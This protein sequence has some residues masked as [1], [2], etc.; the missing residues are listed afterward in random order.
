MSEDKKF[1]ETA[2]YNTDQTRECEKT[3]NSDGKRKQ[4]N[5]RLTKSS[6]EADTENK[7]DNR[8]ET[9]RQETPILNQRMSIEVEVIPDSN[10]SQN[11]GDVINNESQISNLSKNKSQKKKAISPESQTHETTNTKDKPKKIFKVVY[12]KNDTSIAPETKHSRL[13][14]DNQRLKVAR[15]GVNSM[16]ILLKHR[17]EK[18]GLVLKKV[19]VKKLFGNIN[20]Q[21]WFVKR[22]MKYIFA[23]KHANKKVIKIMIK[24]DSIFKKL[25]NLTF[26]DF[27]IN[28][29]LV[30]NRYLP[31]NKRTV[32]F[33][34]HLENFIKCLEN[35]FEKNE[36]EFTI[37]ENEEYVDKLMITGT[38]LIY[39]INGGGNY[40]PRCNR[41]RI[42]NKICFIKYK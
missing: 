41:K 4:D 9:E 13:T 6:T 18:Q 36:N 42:K 34:A 40:D 14:K 17:C 15:M 30:N 27:Y 5:K 32:L 10:V 28:Y 2:E 33:L 26:E 25:V 37:E 23:S 35:E 1:Y 16:F 12:R 29:F 7:T 24:K 3:E 8:E 31:I 39:E 21:K 38:S 11:N 22:K 19:K 20:K